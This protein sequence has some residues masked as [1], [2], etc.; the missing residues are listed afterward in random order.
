MFLITGL[1][2]IGREYEYTPHNAGFLFLDNLYEYLKHQEG[3]SVEEWEDQSRMFDSLICK[4]KRDG[5]VVGVFQKPTTYMNL[6]GIAVSK[7]YDKYEID[8]YILVHDDLDIQ[9]GKYKIQKDKSPKGHNGV[10]SVEQHLKEKDFLRVRLGIENRINMNIP[11]EEY[12]ISKY[13]DQEL[14]TLNEEIAEACK[15]L[16]L[17]LN[18]NNHI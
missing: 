15:D 11:G 7:V 10:I 2:N 8:E 12:V 13:T 6:S 18:N 5:K 16:F 1:G 3:W 17:L 14:I 9:L 4:V